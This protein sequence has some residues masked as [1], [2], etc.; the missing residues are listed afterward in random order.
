ML[1][2][3]FANTPNA[4][5]QGEEKPQIGMA[6]GRGN[7]ITQGPRK[8]TATRVFQVLLSLAAAI[9]GIYAAVVCELYLSHVSPTNGN[10]IRPSKRQGRPRQR[11]LQ[12]RTL[13]TLSPS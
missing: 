13:F 6:D 4:A 12:L 7:L 9:P 2:R 5:Q 10:L 8:R 1:E 3:E 11:V